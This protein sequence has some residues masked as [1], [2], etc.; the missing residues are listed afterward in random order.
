MRGKEDI[1]IS[2]TLI[3]FLVVLPFVYPFFFLAST[4]LR[5]REDYESD[6]LGLPTRITLD[7]LTHAWDTA[8]LG[9]ALV[10]TLFAAGVGACVVAVI[11]SAG[12][13]WFYRHPQRG[14]KVLFLALTGAWA[15]P[16]VTWLI[17]FF[18]QMSQ[19]GLTNNLVILGIVYGTANAP[20]GLYLIWTYYREAITPD[21]TE[22]AEMDGASYFQQWLRIFIPLSRP[23]LAALAALAFVWSWG[24]LLLA[25][26]LLQESER[27]TITVAA[28]TLITRSDL[29]Y[30]SQ[31]AA[32]LISIAPLAITFLVAQ[33][34]IARGVAASIPK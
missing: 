21:V 6:S 17:P 30:Q 22:A 29:Q 8:G 3:A 32:A 13:Y 9:R 23:A 5:P 19:L 28:A 18:V 7:H 20:F 26:V 31:A 4:A 15:F 1:S 34:A 33:R 16:L 14:A 2:R 27:W 11:S 12:A 24:D 25:A 10:N